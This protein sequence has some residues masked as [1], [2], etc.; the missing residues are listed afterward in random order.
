MDLSLI[1]PSG[2]V[3]N[4][5]TSNP[6]IEFISDESVNGLKREYYAFNP[7]AETGLWT[8]KVAGVNVTN[9]TGAESYTLTGFM[10]Q[11]DIQFALATD[12]ASYLIG[13][14]LTIHATLTNGGA[15]LAGGT[16]NARVIAPDRITITDIVLRDNGVGAD[17]V[18]ND[19]I[20]SGEFTGTAVAG[21][22]QIL[23]SATS[24]SPTDFSR[25]DSVLASAATGGASLDGTPTSTVLDTNSNGLFDVLRLSA[26][27]TATAAGDYRLEASLKDSSGN[28]IQTA[29]HDVSLSP[30]SG[31]VD[32]DFDG[33][34]IF[35]N[36]I[37]GPYTIGSLVLRENVDAIFV[38]ISSA[39]NVHSTAAYPF[40]DFEHDSIALTGNGSESPT[41]PDGNG[42]FDS[43]VVSLEVVVANAG[44]YQF[45]G[46][47][48]DSLGNVA[49]RT[50]GFVS[51]TSG[52]NTLD[53]E[54]VGTDIRASQVD[55][56]YHVAQIVII[57]GGD[58][59]LTDSDFQTRA[60]HAK[61]FMGAFGDELNDT[62]PITTI[63]ATEGGVICNVVL[64][65]FSDDD[66]LTPQS[67]F[68]ANVNWGS[69]VIDAQVTV[70]LVSRTA[71]QSNWRV[72]GMA[73]YPAGSAQDSPFTIHVTVDD[74]DGQ[75][76][77]TSNTTIDVFEAMLPM[78]QLARQTGL[79]GF[80][81]AGLQL[82]EVLQNGSVLTLINAAGVQSAGT[83]ANDTDIDAPGLGLTGVFDQ[84]AGTITFSDSS[85]WFKVRQIAGQWLTS[86]GTVAGI[87]QL[88]TELT[89]HTSGGAG[90]TT[91]GHFVDATHL[92]LNGWA[93]PGGRL[94]GVLTNNGLTIEW[95]NG[96][97]WSLIPDFQG[98][99]V[100]SACLPT[101]I[102]QQGATLLFVNKLGQTSQ[103]TVLDA[104]HVVQGANWGS[105]VG[106]IVGNTLQFTNGTV[107]SIP[108]LRVGYS[109]LGGLW[110]TSN[111]GLDT[112]TLQADQTLTFVN[113]FGQTSAGQFVSPTEVFA[114]DW[115]S[116]GTIVG[117]TIV[118]ESA[119]WTKIPYVSGAYI[120][121]NDCETGINQ[122]ERKLTF[123]DQFGNVTHGTLVSPTSISKTDGSHRTATIAGNVITWSNGPVWTLLPSLSGNWT[124]AG[125]FAPTYTEQAGLSLLFITGSGK[126][127]TGNFVSPI[128]AEVQQTG[129]PNPPTV[130]VG[131]PNDHTLDFPAGIEWTKFPPNLLDDVFADRNFWPFL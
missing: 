89:V 101:R 122:L 25:A 130:N 131:I 107:W 93:N 22:Y 24:S 108:P 48:V 100:N 32:L 28:I 116:H 87:R 120:N 124:V 91:T 128:A 51:L 78:R 29:F 109:D 21:S 41:D 115:N 105:I 79:A 73:T 68:T 76:V 97:V 46:E 27:V 104:T 44:T 59:V 9:P 30:G 92:I 58:A 26:G 66:P 113:R 34:L 49:A 102:E 2:Q 88:G 81:Y 65:T 72:L 43:L 1:S 4:H 31:I 98:D 23:A 18:P 6:N 95:S 45:S 84:S 103:G 54:F 16:V 55:G 35:S 83:I 111:G 82:T 8:L 110:Q 14:T 13:Q 37:D 15:P 47:L 7:G 121:Q 75:S 57:G 127:L 71:T 19:G 69:S 12:A 40:V 60:Y 53:F 38:P 33:R 63:D 123:T 36:G 118:W 67:D 126:V 114:T 20:Y 10:A 94:T 74:I 42:R 90:D 61:D 129:I 80:Y 56:P 86:K 11:S 70:E 96:R 119:V 3:I 50:S 5:A 85:V 39:S 52:V 64:M 99:W 125:S 112:R 77:S 62:T 106:T 117:D 17:T